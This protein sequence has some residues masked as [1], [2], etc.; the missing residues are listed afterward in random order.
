MKP[1]LTKAF[2]ISHFEVHL[3]KEALQ[4]I[5]MKSPPTRNILE[6]IL[7]VFRSKYVKPESQVTAKHEW[8]KLTFDPNTRSISEFLG[9]LEDCTR[10]A[11]GD[12]TQHM[13]DNLFYAKI[14]PH[15]KQFSIR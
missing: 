15:L 1:H 12:N 4:A 13:I 10:K 6:N 5:R 7:M 11:F 14:P 8:H 3:Q 9:E 2:K